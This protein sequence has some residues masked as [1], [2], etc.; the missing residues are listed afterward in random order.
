MTSSAL[1]TRDD[2]DDLRVFQVFGIFYFGAENIP[3]TGRPGQL[4]DCIRAFK[5]DEDFPN[6]GH[7]EHGSHLWPT[8][9][10]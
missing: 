1:A 6:G 4:P 8:I 9:M 10:E 5:Q 7:A 2:S 3:G